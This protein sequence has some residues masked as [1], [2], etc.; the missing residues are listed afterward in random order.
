MVSSDCIKLC[1][2]EVLQHSASNKLKFLFFF[3]GQYGDYDPNFH[4]P[5]F[6]AH[7]ELLPKR[8]SILYKIKSLD[9]LFAT[10]VLLWD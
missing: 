1:K 7:D 10:Q 9:L 6:L 2:Q 4:E 8:V 3:L 5:G